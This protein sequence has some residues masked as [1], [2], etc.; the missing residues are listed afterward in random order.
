MSQYLTVIT[1][2]AWQVTS[3]RKTFSSGYRHLILGRTITLPANHV[4][5]GLP[6]GSFKA[7]HFWNGKRPRIQV[8]LYG[9][10]A[11]VR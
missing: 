9:F 8:P 1:E 3:Y 10:M 5:V 6:S 2:I 7:T 4:T 11:N